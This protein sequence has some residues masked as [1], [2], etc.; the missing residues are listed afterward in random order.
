MGQ[1]QKGTL[2]LAYPITFNV[3]IYFHSI[4]FFYINIQK[5]MILGIDF[6]TF[7]IIFYNKEVFI[8]R[9]MLTQV[10]TNVIYQ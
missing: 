6:F 4:N 9:R 5:K 10:I 2:L 3:F 8:Y 1:S 7:F